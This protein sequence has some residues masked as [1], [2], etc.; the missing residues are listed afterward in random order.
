MN[1]YLETDD[2]ERDT[3]VTTVVTSDK[4]D[5]VKELAAV[6]S[7]SRLLT[8]L[9]NELKSSFEYVSNRSS[10]LSVR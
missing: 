10:C 5:L 3:S 7:D 4:K 2:E 8:D 6:E 9:V 1:G